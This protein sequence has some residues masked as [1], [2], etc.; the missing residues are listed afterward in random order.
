MFDLARML[1]VPGTHNNKAARNGQCG[2][3]VRTLADCGG[4][5]TMAEID[6]RLNDFGIYTEEETPAAANRS[7]IQP[8]GRSPT[9]PAAMS[10]N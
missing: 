8:G 10:R 9:R 4:P 2:A 6:E 3:L 1:R 5:L 7:V